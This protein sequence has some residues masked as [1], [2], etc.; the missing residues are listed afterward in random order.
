M[1]HNKD[2]TISYYGEDFIGYANSLVHAAIFDTMTL[3]SIFLK[4]NI[5][6]IF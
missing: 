6:K 2:T 1:L 3:Y 4:I 5:L